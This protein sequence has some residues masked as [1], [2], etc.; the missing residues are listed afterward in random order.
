MTEWRTR[1]AE[2]PA[3]PQVIRQP[4]WVVVPGV[5]A[6]VSLIGG[7]LLAVALQPDPTRAVWVTISDLAARYASRSYVMTAALSV[8]GVALVAVAAGLI[9][10]RAAG[11]VAL[12]VSGLGVLGAAAAP[13]PD[14]YPAHSLF[15]FVALGSLSIWPCL[16]AREGAAR[17]LG[18]D[19]AT[20]VTGIGCALL[21]ILYLVPSLL[22]GFGMVE[23]LVAGL[24]LI[25]LALVVMECAWRPAAAS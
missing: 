17:R 25:W 22:G 20:T 10:A 18:R 2:L 24:E 9:A 19:R 11:R 15:A 1:S 14:G 13:L 12:A 3:R 5:L 7:W 21:A 4:V 6:P 8:T 23:K 16:G